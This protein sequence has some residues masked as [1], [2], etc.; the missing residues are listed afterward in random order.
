MIVFVA[1]V[2]SIT[3]SMMRTSTVQSPAGGAVAVTVVVGAGLLISNPGWPSRFHSIRVIGVSASVGVEVAVKV[4]VVPATTGVGVQ[5]KSRVGAA[6][7]TPVPRGDTTAP[8]VAKQAV[9]RSL[10]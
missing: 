7:A 4:T 8:T 2:L 5:V 3:P 1:R 10:T 9:S 6:P